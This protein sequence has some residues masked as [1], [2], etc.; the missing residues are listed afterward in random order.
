MRSLEVAAVEPLS[1]SHLYQMDG[2]VSELR[3]GARPNWPQRSSVFLVDYVI[4]TSCA[5]QTDRTS[6]GSANL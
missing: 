1:D 6:R 4:T 3:V 5:P 2:R